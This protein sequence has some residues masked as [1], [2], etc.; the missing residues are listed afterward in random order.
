MLEE[1]LTLGMKVKVNDT[2][3]YQELVGDVGYIVGLSFNPDWTINVTTNE[4]YRNL[5]GS[6]DGWKAS[7]L[8]KVV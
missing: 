4:T 3:P 8:D 6:T 7:E 5:V 1:E 2:C